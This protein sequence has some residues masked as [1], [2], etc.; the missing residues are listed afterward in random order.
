MNNETLDPLLEAVQALRLPR[1]IVMWIDAHD[2]EWGRCTGKHDPY[3]VVPCNDVDCPL[4]V[5]ASCGTVKGG[6]DLSAASTFHKK[7][8]PPL[9]QLLLQGTGL[10]KS[11]PSAETRIPID[12]DALELWSQIRDLVKLWCKQLDAT[13]DGDDLPASLHNWHLAHRNAHRSKRISDVIDADVTRMVESW[14]RMIETKFDPPEK[15]EWK[16]ACPALVPVRN[17]D[18]DEIGYRRCNARRV[19]V[20]D[21][22]QFAISLNVTAMKAEC[23]RCKTRWVGERGIMQLRYETNRWN[24]EKAEAEA[25]RVAALERLANGDT[26][27]QVLDL[28]ANSV[29]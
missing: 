15:R 23:A 3:G 22:E 17:V 10:S 29:A 13:F 9:L 6:E 28:K 19:V 7:T 5:C 2:H 4:E 12:V 1:Q 25:E 20:G 16:D 27:N 11:S 18:G 14:V 26:P 21:T 8:H 24:A